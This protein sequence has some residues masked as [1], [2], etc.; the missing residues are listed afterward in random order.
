MSA[1]SLIE[2]VP[3]QLELI[4][5]E[6]I[7]DGYLADLEAG[8]APKLGPKKYTQNWTAARL[9]SKNPERY[10]LIVSVIAEGLPIRWICQA[11]KVSHH[12]IQAIR[13][14]EPSIIATE[15]RLLAGKHRFASRICVEKIIEALEHLEPKDLRDVQSLGVLNGILVEKMQ[16]LDGEATSIVEKPKGPTLDD[17]RRVYEALPGDE[18]AIDV[19]AAVLTGSEAAAAGQKERGP[20]G[21][22]E[23]EVPASEAGHRAAKAD[24]AGLGP[25]LSLSS[26]KA[27]TGDRAEAGTGDLHATDSDV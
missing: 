26:T 8:A 19:D 14:R 21:P 18:P 2:T 3:E 16:L 22:M 1:E 13:E 23:A 12:S 6:D 15:K 9:F 17:I 5:S 11:F 7:P 25:A 4:G 20:G 24:P 10:R 27:D